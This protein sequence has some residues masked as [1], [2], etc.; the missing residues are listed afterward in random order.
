MPVRS[1]PSLASWKCK[2]L[3]TPRHATIS[4]KHW[5]QNQNTKKSRERGQRKRVLHM[6]V[7]SYVGHLFFHISFADVRIDSQRKKKKKDFV[8]DFLPENQLASCSHLCILMPNVWFIAELWNSTVHGHQAIYLHHTYT[9]SFILTLIY[10][11]KIS[12]HF[13]ENTQIQREQTQSKAIS[14]ES[15]CREWTAPEILLM[16]KFLCNFNPNVLRWLNTILQS[17]ASGPVSSLI[18]LRDHSGI[19]HLFEILKDTVLIL[20]LLVHG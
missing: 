16:K 2:T 6:P 7:A 8:D 18:P 5:W 12:I 17:S 9:E 19:K 11:H 13:R 10:G 14:I 20:L 15:C 3:L 1:P 4:T